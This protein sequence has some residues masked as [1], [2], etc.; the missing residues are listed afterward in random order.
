MALA[1]LAPRGLLAGPVSVDAFG[2]RAYLGA[3]APVSGGPARRQDNSRRR[4]A[5]SG[6]A[7]GESAPPSRAS[8][9]A[10]PGRL[11]SSAPDSHQR[12]QAQRLPA[13][14]NLRHQNCGLAH[15]HILGLLR[16][17]LLAVLTWREGLPRVPAAPS[18]LAMATG[19]PLSAWDGTTMLLPE[20][21]SH[22]H[23]HTR[24]RG[25]GVPG[26]RGRHT[27]APPLHCP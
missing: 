19:S 21:L 8:S 25:G 14:A 2:M 4:L 24:R 23:W 3:D 11:P 18:P 13:H 7:R 10:A 15:P 26:R 16:V 22:H 20:S 9:L 6:P 1:R 27:A 17:S 5:N 12:P